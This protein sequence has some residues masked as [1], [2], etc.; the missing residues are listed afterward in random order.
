MMDIGGE[1]RQKKLLVWDKV[2]ENGGCNKK[3][4]RSANSSST[5]NSINH[6][7]PHPT[8]TPVHNTI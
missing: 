3:N 4:N 1:N 5:T 8:S 6:P 7:T 2:Y